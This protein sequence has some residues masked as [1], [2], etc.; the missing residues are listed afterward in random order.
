MQVIA[1]KSLELLYAFK[2]LNKKDNAWS[3]FQLGSLFNNKIEINGRIYE[4]AIIGSN[5][6]VPDR[7]DRLAGCGNA[8][9]PQIAELLFNQI[10]VLE[11]I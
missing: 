6:G 9:V 7:M 8:I 1:Y 3:S 2:R 4:S 10:K 5:D 11:A